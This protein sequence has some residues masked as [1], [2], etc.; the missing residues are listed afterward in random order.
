MQY[1]IL[2]RNDA[3]SLMLL[4]NINAFFKGRS[5]KTLKVHPNWLNSSI[6][7]ETYH[8]IIVERSRSEEYDSLGR[9]TTFS[10][11]SRAR[12]NDINILIFQSIKFSSFVIFK[13]R[14]YI[15][16]IFLCK[17][18]FAYS[19]RRWT[20]RSTIISFNARIVSTA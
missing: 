10:C 1:S 4:Q 5:H 7:F 15:F 20:T 18:T 11:V 6:F 14:K 8:P 12:L 16:H 19:A 3:V 13:M 17:H 9:K 2:F